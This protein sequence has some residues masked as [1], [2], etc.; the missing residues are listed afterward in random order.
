MIS[1]EID[2]V[3]EGCKKGDSR[4]QELLYKNYYEAMVRLCI[5][6]TKNDDDAVE[7]LNNGFLKVFR[8]IH[9]FDSRQATLYTWIRKI[10]INACLDFIRQNS[11]EKPRKAVDMYDSVHI[12]PDVLDTLHAEDIL[13]L[14]RTL[15]AVTRAVFNL[16]VVDGY[17]HKEIGAL[18]GISEGASRWYLCEARKALQKI[19]E[20]RA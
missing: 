18:L 3:I 10:I 13:R 2:K 20:Q 4:A 12:N 5:M 11:R 1:A 16:H 19:I 7:A 14:V 9:L 6:Y 17:A 8:N 15:P